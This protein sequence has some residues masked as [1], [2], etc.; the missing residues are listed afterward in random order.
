[1]E[2]TLGLPDPFA[3]SMPHLEHVLKGIKVRQGQIKPDQVSPEILRWINALGQPHETD[4]NFIMLWA[5]CC[6]PVRG[7]HSANTTRI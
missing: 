1:M 7:D 4:P 3:V 2:I 5:A 6:F